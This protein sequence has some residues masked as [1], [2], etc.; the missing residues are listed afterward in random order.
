M[1]RAKPA[2]IDKVVRLMALGLA[3]ALILGCIAGNVDPRTNRLIPFFGLAYPFFLLL[4]IL[5]AGWWLLR[6]RW[7]FMVLT[8][9]VIL[10][11]W[12]A[13]N[14]TFS[15]RGLSGEGPKIKS[16]LIRMMTYN[17]HSF[18]P[19]DSGNV[20]SVK[21]QM[22]QVVR[23]EN[24]DIMCFQEYYTRKKGSYAITDSLKKMLNTSYYYFVP[25]SS[26]DYEAM[27]L[28]IFSKYP[29]KNKGNIVFEGHGGNSSI[30]VDVQVQQKLLRIYNV[31]LQSISFDK[32]DY[33]YLDKVTKKMD[34]EIVPSK[35][36]LSM[37][38]T[39]FLKRSAQVD[40]MKAHMKTCTIPFLISGDFNDTPASYAVTQMTA[41]LSKTFVKKGSGLGRTYNGKFPNFQIDYIAVTKEMEVINHRIIEAR[42]SDHFPIRSDLR[43]KP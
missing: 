17:V 30:Y 35:R 32:Q 15:F 9:G 10:L 23:D 37:L 40:I 34:P 22:L 7:I 13:L 28:A 38:N 42:L 39:A 18:R 29:I 14:A 33:Q 8:I 5:M 11:G 6:K 16:D 24:P 36:I 4:N 12:R 21:R 3:L 26:N 31:H 1:K 2:F 19:Y 20:E 25:T 41:G 27:G 43:L